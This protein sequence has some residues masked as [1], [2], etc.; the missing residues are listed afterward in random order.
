MGDAVCTRCG[1]PAGECLCDVRLVARNMGASIYRL[2]PEDLLIVTVPLE[3]AVNR[4]DSPP[5]F[6]QL[7]TY[8]VEAVVE[9]S[10]VFER[11]VDAAAVDDELLYRMG[12]SPDRKRLAGIIAQ[13]LAGAEPP[14]S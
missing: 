8:C 5:G 2:E 11:P 4:E 7:V 1:K 14:E 12:P 6:P 10:A 9:G 13:L 3:K